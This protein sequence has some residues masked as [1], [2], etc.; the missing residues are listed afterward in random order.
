MDIRL[1]D[2]FTKAGGRSP[3]S[4]IAHDAER[5]IADLRS[6]LTPRERVL[7]VTVLYCSREN[8]DE[9][10]AWGLALAVEGEIVQMFLEGQE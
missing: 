2:L 10:I 5:Q 1:R 7:E 3:K 6:R 4:R 8:V 9:A